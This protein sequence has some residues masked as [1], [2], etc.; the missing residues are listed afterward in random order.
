MQ[1]LSIT[2]IILIVTIALSI[3]ALSNHV[4][5]RWLIF[6][7]YLVNHQKQWYRFFSSGFIH[8]DWMHLLVNM[9][10]LY[11]FGQA[12]ESYYG[13]VFTDKSSY[14]FVLLYMGG[15]LISSAP[16][17]VKNKENSWYNSLGA[18]GAVSGILFAAILFEPWQK[19]YIYG[20]IGLPGIVLGPLYLLYEYRSGKR[21]GDNINHDAHFWGAIFGVA[22]T[23]LLKP[24]IAVHFIN[25]LL[26]R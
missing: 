14:Y 8:A 10:V 9:F 2:L 1:S 23:I 12:V 25:T 7:P 11:G 3:L 24:A 16:T 13:A 15:L 22:F 5:M 26:D 20:I 18:S 19:I 17:Y 21:G 4:I 6:N